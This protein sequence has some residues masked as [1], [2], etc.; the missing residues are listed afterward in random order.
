MVRKLLSLIHPVI[1]VEFEIIIRYKKVMAQARWHVRITDMEV[2]ELIEEG[3]KFNT[4]KLKAI[5][6]VDVI[7]I[8]HGRWD[9]NFPH[10][11]DHLTESNTYNTVYMKSFQQIRR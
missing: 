8:C 11:M 9:C 1:D 3:V 7:H 4:L 2:I 6:V 5:Y 10:H